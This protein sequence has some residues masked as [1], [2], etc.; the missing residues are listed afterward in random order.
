MASYR[1]FT[2]LVVTATLALVG[3]GGFLALGP[4]FPALVLA[5]PLLIVL[6][7]YALVALL[8]PRNAEASSMGVVP[9][10]ALAIALSAAIAPI[11]AVG[12]NFVTGIY[13][14]PVLATIAA[15]TLVTT[16]FAAIRRLRVPTEAR[17]SMSPG[18]RLGSW[19]TRYFGGTTNLHARTPL[20]ARRGRD[21]FLNLVVLAAILVFAASVG[22][23]A[24][25]PQKDAY[26]EAYLA[27]T[28]NGNLSLV[29]SP[30]SMTS[31]QRNTLVAV[32][33]NHEGHSQKYT[34]EV[35]SQVVNSQGA[36]QKESVV[37]TESK[38][39][40][41]GG[42]WRMSVPPTPNGNRIAVNVYKGDRNAQNKPDFHLTLGET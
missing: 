12:A 10:F 38:T 27:T 3:I 41:A 26:S 31:A 32:I 20:E 16:V 8:Y 21:V 34:V 17:V 36:V 22:I 2:D 15:I 29:E 30:A 13:A 28:N 6:P 35:R 37:K 7:G 9:R 4:S 5:L 14:R 19:T 25:I 1:Q 33:D 23:A 42:E 40:P 11:V 18:R 24:V 39:V